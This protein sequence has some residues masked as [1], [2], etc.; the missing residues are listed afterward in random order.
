[1]M[2]EYLVEAMD[3]HRHIKKLTDKNKKQI[4]HIDKTVGEIGVAD[5][6]V[7]QEQEK[8]EEELQIQKKQMKR[9]N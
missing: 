2:G 7:D 3:E 8:P 4:E 9:Q 1:M 5:V 6:Y